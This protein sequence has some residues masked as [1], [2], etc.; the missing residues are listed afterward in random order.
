MKDIEEGVAAFTR[1][2]R[3][4]KEGKVVSQAWLYVGELYT[5]IE[6]WPKVIESMDE[7]RSISRASPYHL[8]GAAKLISKALTAMGD[9]D[10][11]LSYNRAVLRWPELPDT[12]KFSTYNRIA[13]IHGS[14]GDLAEAIRTLEELKVFIRTLGLIDGYGR[15]SFPDGTGK[16]V[17]EYVAACKEISRLQQSVQEA[18]I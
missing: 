17:W 3:L 11:A 13:R 5:L 16:Q 1:V 9:T 14:R 4:W 2:V 6:A 18:D 15:Y 8:V 12:F 7:M 10:G